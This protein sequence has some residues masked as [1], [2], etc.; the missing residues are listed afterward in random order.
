MVTHHQTLP[1][2]YHLMAHMVRLMGLHQINVK[3]MMLNIKHYCACASQFSCRKAEFAIFW[4]II[5]QHTFRTIDFISILQST[6]KFLI[7]GFEPRD[8]NKFPTW[9]ET[10]TSLGL[11]VPSS[12]QAG[13]SYNWEFLENKRKLKSS[14]I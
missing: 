2:H 11:A 9:Q 7:T 3:N 8:N 10:E 12:G 4:F 5:S 13:A 6:K 1:Y 14:S